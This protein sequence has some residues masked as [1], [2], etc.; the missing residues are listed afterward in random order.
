MGA[1]QHRVAIGLAALALWL[2]VAPSSGAIPDPCVEA[3]G[4]GRQ[5]VTDLR[6]LPPSSAQRDAP[7]R[8][9]VRLT[10][11]D[12]TI[13]ILL[14][15]DSS[16]TSGIADGSV[17]LPYHGRVRGDPG[18]S[19]DALV[20]SGVLDGVVELRDVTLLVEPARRYCAAAASDA[21]VVSRVSSSARGVAP[22][23]S[24]TQLAPSW[25][26]AP[27]I[28]PV[29]PVAA[30]PTLTPT[31]PAQSDSDEVTAN[32][33]AAAAGGTP[34]VNRDALAAIGQ[35]N[36]VYNTLN[37]ATAMG[38]FFPSGLTRDRSVSQTRLYVA[39]V[40]NSRVL[41]FECSGTNCALPTAAAAVRV[42]GQP[43]FMHWQS[44]GGVYSTVSAATL[45][46]PTGAAIDASGTLYVADS[47]NNRVLIYFDAW[48]DATADVVLGQASMTTFAAGSALNQLNAPQAVWVDGSGAV[49]VADAGNNRILKF[50]S[51]SNGASAVLA[52][53]GAGGPSATTLSGP[54]DVAMDGTGNL[55]VAD[56]GFNRVL[57]YAAPITNGEAAAAAFGQGGSLTS[58]VANLGGV[59][60]NSLAGP[61]K[62][63]LDASGRL[64]IADTQNNRVLEY[65]TPLSST[66]ATRV[67]GQV[68]RNQVPSFATNVQDGPDGIVNAAGLFHPRGVVTDGSGRLWVSDYEWSRVLGFDAALGAP[69]D[70]LVA[71]RVLGKELLIDDFANQPSANRLNNPFG[72]AVDRS[73]TPNRLWVADIGNARVLGY[74]STAAIATNM[75]ADIVLGQPDFV[76]GSPRRGL[77]GPLANTSNAVTSNAA[78]ETPAHLAVDS[79]GGVYV[80]DSGNSRVLEF[81]DPFGTD[82][83]GDRVFGQNDFTNINPK[84]PLGTASA[85]IGPNGVGID[86]SD[87]LYVADTG[88][89]RVLR[90]NN[91]PAKPATGASADLILGQAAFTSSNTYPV[92]SPGC[93]INRMNAPDGV[94]AAP[95]G[96]VY[97]ADSGNHR[98]LVF[99]P[100]FTNGMNASAVF[101]QADFTHCAANRGGAAS[102]LTLNRPRGIFEDPD[103]NVYIADYGNNRVLVYDTPF[104]GG[105]FAADEVLGQPDFS[106]TGTG[107]PRPDTLVLPAQIDMDSEG[108]LFIADIDDSRV[109]R[110]ATKS[111]PVVLLDPIPSPIIIGQHF[112]VSGT[113]FTAGSRLVLFVSTPS[114]VQAFTLTP[115]GW[116]SGFLIT[117]MDPTIPLGNGFGTVVVVNTDQNFIQSNPES[118]YMYGSPSFN[119]PTIT[120]INGIGLRPFD[121]TVPVASVE[122]AVPKPS[123]VTI[124]GTGFN[125]PLV[126]LFMPTSAVLLTPVAGGT[127]TQIQVDVPGTVSTGPGAFQVVNNPYQPNVVS[128]AV[129]VALGARL[130]I[131]GVVQAGNTITVNGTGFSPSS[132]INFFNQ[133]GAAVLNLGGYNAQ[134]Q[135]NIPLTLVSDMQ[136]T[137]TIPAAALPGS[138]YI[139]VINP[140]FIPFSSTGGDPHGAFTLH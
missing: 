67:F 59:S 24:A 41:G 114:G 29:S 99:A 37:Q 140:P 118:Q 138:A 113:G 34:I 50:T 26:T 64:W 12:R 89:H 107:A 134:G 109:T 39:D 17:P 63:H 33:A 117:F 46:F 5:R 88:N 15:R 42:F 97:V 94:Y 28:A 38:F 102:N 22:P 112:T 54:R 35:E 105:D 111:P 87:D 133:Q 49:W 16:T 55:Y 100:P 121:D 3:F 7:L 72:V 80:V 129:S 119:L 65:D 127:A 103:G 1:C 82:T 14:R 130:T 25:Q 69:P 60:A 91:A 4:S 75:N 30:A 21:L 132:V 95:S 81:D 139:Q 48:N 135:A 101:G 116:T 40:A 96:R 83:V 131:S 110:Y 13:E 106:S 62:L 61:E 124:T 36:L 44:N 66:T 123:R 125:A 68:D 43:D 10:A 45:S 8:L 73:H 126:N 92:Y 90:F 58:G 74:Q 120:G 104:S 57:R 6:F 137:F 76:H 108:R 20:G 9:H 85:L 11:F 86:A 27:T 93:T 2:T 47:G 79:H 70:A 122:T 84:F 71:D 98:V 18:S 32:A 77:N 51:L 78:F 115:D 136:F 128:N 23:S 52:L 31:P 19:V 53:G 56:T